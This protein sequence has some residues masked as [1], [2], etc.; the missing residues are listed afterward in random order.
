MG[1]ETEKADAKRQ[2]LKAI[3]AE[4]LRGSD[5][6]DSDLLADRVVQQFADVTAPYYEA[7]PMRLMTFGEGGIGGGSTTKPGNVMLNIGKLVRAIAS[8]ILTIAGA[9]TAPWLLVIGALVTW[10]ALWSCLNLK[11]TEEHACAV[12]VLW[13]NRDDNNTFP[14]SEVLGAV[15]RERTKFGMR[16]LSAMAIDRALDDLVKMRCIKQSASDPER[17]WLREWVQIK[18][19]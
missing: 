6:D 8:G 19:R 17:W 3:I 13:E 14:K 12:W 1:Y 10:D 15:N 7:E 5:I 18:Y 16:P 9:T 11:L 4:S 2:D